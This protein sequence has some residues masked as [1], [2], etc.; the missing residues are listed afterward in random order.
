MFAISQRANELGERD[1]IQLVLEE[2]VR[3]TDSAIGYLHFVNDDQEGI[4][5][6]AWSAETLKQCTAAYDN[7]YPISAAGIW[8][9]SV[10]LRR[11]V[12]H[13]EYQNLADRKVYP[14]GH[15][16]LIRHIGVP[17]IDGGK[18][19]MLMGVG[20]K[21]VDY[22]DADVTQLQAIGNDLWPIVVRRRVEV[23]LAEA[24]KAAEAANIAKSAFL[25]N[26]SHEIRTPMN[27]IVG[28]VNI[29]R[30]EG[31]TPRQVERLETIDKSAQHLL[32]VINNILDLSKIEAGKL[33]LEGAPV[34]IDSMM[35]NVSSILAER[36]KAKGLRLAIETETIPHRL[37][38]DPTRLRQALLN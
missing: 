22:D 23:A 35:V 18:V 9:D 11:P 25:A 4:Q 30:R 15:A 5:L 17:V 10:R 37:L 38:G 3:L 19:R 27:G 26:M 13:N 21:T 32:S 33:D 34:A 8:A 31:L 12:I 36:A 1:L 7:H 2:A 29:L 20:N 24:K 28:M 6:V 16:H 14:E